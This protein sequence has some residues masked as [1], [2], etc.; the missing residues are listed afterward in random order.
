MWWFCCNVLHCSSLYSSPWI[1]LLLFF[2]PLTFFFLQL[3]FFDL[4]G[5]S[6]QF[7][8]TT[9]N[10]TAHWTPCKPSG[11]V[12]H[13]GGDRRAHEGSNLGAV[14][15]DKPL[16]PPGQDPQCFFCNFACVIY[17]FFFFFFMVFS[18]CIFSEVQGFGQI[19][20]QF[21]LMR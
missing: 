8:R 11:H 4:R 18:I 19:S 12:R 20:E 1:I 5:C 7:A 9:T 2:C 21:D 15:G 13:R 17:G 10:F 3:F 6:G 14:E 16:P